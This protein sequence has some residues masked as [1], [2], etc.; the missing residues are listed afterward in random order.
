MRSYL[1][2]AILLFSFQ[3]VHAGCE[4]WGHYVRM[5]PGQSTNTVEIEIANGGYKFLS[6]GGAPA[7]ALLITTTT[8][9][10]DIQAKDSYLENYNYQ[11]QTFKYIWYAR[12][13]QGGDYCDCQE[14]VESLQNASPDPANFRIFDSC[15]IDEP[16]ECYQVDKWS[17]ITVNKF[18]DILEYKKGNPNDSYDCVNGGG[19][20]DSVH[21]IDGVNIKT[22]Y[23]KGQ[24]LGKTCAEAGFINGLPPNIWKKFKKLLDNEQDTSTNN[25]TINIDTTSVN[26]T[27]VQP[28]STQTIQKDYTNHFIEIKEILAKIFY[29]ITGF[30]ESFDSTFDMSSVSTAP[31]DDFTGPDLSDT[32]VRVVSDSI[33]RNFYSKRDS[34][35][36]YISQ[37]S[38][39][40][41]DSLINAMNVNVNAQNVKA[42]AFGN[43]FDFTLDY[44][45]S[46]CDDGL[47]AITLPEFLGSKVV[48]FGI[49][50]LNLRAYIRPLLLLLTALAL[51]ALWIQAIFSIIRGL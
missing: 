23:V 31:I 1:W 44:S 17:Y 49:C 27:I 2:V 32:S 9:K 28:D 29:S 4:I 16:V 25:D 7:Q 20:F 3:I 37:E 19:C 35:R 38:K 15:D 48:D 8:L 51:I 36:N 34:L 22:G 18:G 41:V 50:D 11:G 24:S 30:K 5:T 33:A 39:R 26:D 42:I 12:G 13:F 46:D 14:T 45:N 43:K 6:W 10:A 40:E 21:I 47:F